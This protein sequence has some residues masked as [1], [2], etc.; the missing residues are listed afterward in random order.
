MYLFPGSCLE[1][2]IG[3]PPYCRPECVSSFECSSDK[4]C[5]NMRCVNSCLNNPCAPSAICDVR[6]HSPLCRCPAGYVGNAFIHCDVEPP[7]IKVD[8][9]IAHRDPC[10]PSPCGPFSECRTVGESYVCSCLPGYQFSSPPNC[11]PECT[12]SEECSNEKACIRNTCSGK[13]K[14]FY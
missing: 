14:F 1:Q 8:Q 3:T 2:Y 4:A 7:P 9:P 6:N 11:R 5:T 12:I 13:K 10:Y